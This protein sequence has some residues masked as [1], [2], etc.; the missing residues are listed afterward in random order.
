MDV[1]HQARL[2]R[3][4]CQRSSNHGYINQYD[5]GQALDLPSAFGQKG[6]NSCGPSSLAMLVDAFKRGAGSAEFPAL[7]DLYD[8]TVTG[9]NFT[10]A[11][12]LGAAWS[13]GYLDAFT[14]T[15]IDQINAWLT[16]GVPV[17]A[18]TTFGSAAW[19]TAGGGHVILI[20]GGTEAGDYVVSDP[21]GDYYSS[22][23]GHYGSQ[24]CGYNVV[25]PKAGV[26]ANAANR[27]PL[28]V[29]NRAGA[30]PQVLVAVGGGPSGGRGDFVFWLEDGLG[31]RVGWPTPLG[32]LS[33]IPMSWAGIDPIVPSSPDAPPAAIDTDHAPYAAVLLLPVSDLLLRIQS[34]GPPAAYAIQLRVLEKGRLVSSTVESGTLGA[35]ELR[36]VAVPE[37]AP[38]L[39]SFASLLGLAAIRRGRGLRP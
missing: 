6:G 25:Y 33:Q 17:L 4:R 18:S 16:T 37:P 36:T 21:A 34:T 19:G 24:K 14:G 28:A 22:S 3:E 31:R 2:R 13:M 10:W 29:P 26:E 35:G 39:A 30:D 15:G 7:K 23:T 20:T 11:D 27:S 8:A 5:A 12:G 9:G 32:P 38:L 1:R